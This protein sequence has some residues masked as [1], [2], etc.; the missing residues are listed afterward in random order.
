MSLGH[1]SKIVREGLVLHLDAANVKS[2]P[3]TGTVWTDLANKTSTAL[4]NGVTYSNNTF[5]FDGIDDYVDC[6]SASFLNGTLTG[7]TV[8][9]WYKTNGLGTAILAENG[10]NFK[11]NTFYIGQENSLN[12][13]FL[14]ANDSGGYQRIYGTSSYNINTWYNFVGVWSS[15]S[16]LLAYLNGQ[17]TSQSLLNPF[18]NIA[19][20]RT[21]DTNLWIGRRPGG[22]IP[23]YGNLSHCSIYNRA[24][25]SAEVNQNFNALRG[26]YGI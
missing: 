24:L 21:G 22:S 26:R 7:L 14:V 9:V 25:T 15:G 8:S 2:Y 3:G 5:G 10:S 12:L 19:S 13:S 23:L 17:D 4:T 11:T 1:G 16:S 18:G 6:G 20:V